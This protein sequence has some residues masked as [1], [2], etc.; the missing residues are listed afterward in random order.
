[1]FVLICGLK[2]GIALNHINLTDRPDL[3]I[4]SNTGGAAYIPQDYDP[5]PNAITDLF[6]S[7]NPGRE[8][9]RAW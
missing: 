2:I 3:K 8:V 9:K 5:P 1:M 6:L 4:K 7:P